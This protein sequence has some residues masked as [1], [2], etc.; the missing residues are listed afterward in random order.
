MLTFGVVPTFLRLIAGALNIAA[1]LL[2]GIL[3]LF[4]SIMCRIVGGVACFARFLIYLLLILPLPFFFRSRIDGTAAG[5]QR[6]RTQNR[7]EYHSSHNF[8]PVSGML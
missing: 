6:K 1:Q 8:L 3:G 7:R 5:S 4:G 2:S